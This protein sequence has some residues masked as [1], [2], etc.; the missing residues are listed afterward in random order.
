MALSPLYNEIQLLEQ[1]AAGSEPAFEQL[2]TGY[3]QQLGEY[4]FRITESLSVT[5][6]IV[7]DVFMKVWLKRSILPQ[8]DSFTNYLF[9]LSRNHTLNYLKKTAAERTRF[10]QWA[11]DFEEADHPEESEIE[12]YRSWIEEA[13]NALPERQKEIFI[14]NRYQRLTQPQIAER[15]AISPHTVKTHLE[16]ATA[17][18]KTHVQ[19]KIP[20]A[21]LFLFLWK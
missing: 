1:T 13:I 18:I 7:Q 8:L 14:L 15:L 12:Q 10:N 6:E 11:R 21:I 4:I 17:S 9:I 3:H 20:A 2:F 19:T 16:R 5:E